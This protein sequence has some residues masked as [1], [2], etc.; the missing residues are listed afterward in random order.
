VQHYGGRFLMYAMCVR[1]CACVR[2]CERE[3]GMGEILFVVT[4]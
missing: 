2:A 1:A 4:P 3:G